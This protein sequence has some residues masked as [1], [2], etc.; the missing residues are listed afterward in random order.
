MAHRAVGQKWT[1]SVKFLV[2]IWATC[3]GGR[4]C[5][6][7]SRYVADQFAAAPREDRRS[8]GEERPVL[9]ATVGGEQSEETA[10][11]KRGSA[12]RRAATAEGKGGEGR[13]ANSLKLGREGQEPD[14]ESSGARRL[15][16][17]C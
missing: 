1:K 4:S 5:P 11:G 7:E 9:L 17:Y 13:Q 8:S 3:G 12:D 6:S 10:F 16:V 15:G 14:E 2:S